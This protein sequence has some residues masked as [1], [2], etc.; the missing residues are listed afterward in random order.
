[1]VPRVFEPVTRGFVVILVF[2]EAIAMP[3]S[4]RFIQDS[5]KLDYLLLVLLIEVV[6]LIVVVLLDSSSTA[7]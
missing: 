1:L 3:R 4:G 7:G 2:D 6:L 5:S